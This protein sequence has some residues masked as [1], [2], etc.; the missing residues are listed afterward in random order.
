M[1]NLPSD[2]PPGVTFVQ[3]WRHPDPERQERYIQT[4]RDNVALLTSQP[5]FRSFRLLAGVDGR[6]S[7]VVAEWADQAAS[8][9]ATGTA[10]AVAAHDRMAESGEPSGSFYQQRE[11]W[12]FDPSPAT[13]DGVE[14]HRVSAGAGE[15]HFVTAG[16]SGVPVLLVHGFPETWW[17]FRKLIPLLAATHRVIAV[18]LPGTGDSSH[19]DANYDSGTAAAALR[20]LLLEL[21][22]GP[23]HLLGQDIGGPATYRLAATAPD[24]VRS[25]TFVESGLSGFGLEALMDVANGG[26]WHFGFL[27]E[28]GIPEMLLRGH[29]REFF[30][31]R[32]RR[33]RAAVLPTD[34]DEFL[35]TYAGPGGWAGSL[36]RYQSMV[37][38]GAELQQLGQ[39]P[40]AMP[41]LAVGAGGEGGFGDFSRQT[42]AR[43][44]TRVEDVVIDGTGHFI[45]QE[46]PDELAW[47]LLA[48][49]A[50]VESSPAAIPPETDPNRS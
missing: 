9:A 15:L 50:R 27:A 43:V 1:S 12:V 24:L 41:V 45:A 36:G 39:T 21:E 40:L 2:P 10:E 42:M 14:H 38:E 17:A 37:R 46:S 16:A 44:A 13:I 31:S 30:E 22:L 35:R 32:Y 34:I 33:Q 25:Y 47:H 8:K 19:D 5:G 29:E 26:S 3:I 18:D 49:Y 4:V 23:V 20:D 28:P 6:S 48:F 7:A 11:R